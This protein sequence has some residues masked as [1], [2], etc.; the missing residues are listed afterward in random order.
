MKKYI[1]ATQTSANILNDYIYNENHKKLC[2]C[3]QNNKMNN[4]KKKQ[5]IK[6]N[7]IN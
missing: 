7:E 2:C 5:S 4:N 3:K 6:R 1:Y